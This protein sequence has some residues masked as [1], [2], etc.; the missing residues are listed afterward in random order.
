[1]SKNFVSPFS[2]QQFYQH[3]LSHFF[4]L[5]L[6]I[7]L[8]NSHIFICDQS[9]SVFQIRKWMDISLALRQNY[10]LKNQRHFVEFHCLFLSQMH[11]FEYK[12]LFADFIAIKNDFSLKSFMVKSFTPFF[13]SLFRS[14]FSIFLYFIFFRIYVSRADVRVNTINQNYKWKQIS[15]ANL[16][17]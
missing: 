13:H 11:T 7:T 6:F 1:M 8:T 17:K 4:A 16:Y 15:F 14:S 12:S 3:L 2:C 9:I 5:E 10:I